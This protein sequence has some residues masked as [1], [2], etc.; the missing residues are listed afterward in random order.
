MYFLIGLLIEYNP[1]RKVM[2]R[3]MQRK[4]EETVKDENGTS[5][6]LYIRN[7]EH[8][9]A[10]GIVWGPVI[11]DISKRF[12]WTVASIHTDRPPGRPG[13]LLVLILLDIFI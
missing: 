13:P 7:G 5:R 1:K 4:R 8:R 9:S 12:Y 2:V 3:V 10:P 11:N 6:D